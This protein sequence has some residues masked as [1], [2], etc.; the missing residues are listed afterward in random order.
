MICQNCGGLGFLSQDGEDCSVCQGSGE[1][2]IALT[3]RQE[4]ILV[5]AAPG[6]MRPE[7]RHAAALLDL[8]AED[9]D[10]DDPMDDGG[11]EVDDYVE[12]WR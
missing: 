6:M 1:V 7:P 3:I 2:G 9:L 10:F 11:L 12:M 5:L 4:A 8:A